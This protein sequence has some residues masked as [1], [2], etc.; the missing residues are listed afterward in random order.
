MA[1]RP[2]FFSANEPLGCWFRV[3]GRTR[4]SRPTRTTSR[5]SGRHLKSSGEKTRR[6]MAES[7]H[8]DARRASRA[9]A[10]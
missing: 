10:R 2:P 3:N 6:K 1:I 9:R 5:G 8:G 7:H 4:S